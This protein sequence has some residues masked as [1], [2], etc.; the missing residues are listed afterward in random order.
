M[1]ERATRELELRF[2]PRDTNLSLADFCNLRSQ[3]PTGDLRAVLTVNGRPFSESECHVDARPG[4]SRTHHG[5]DPASNRAGWA[6][7]DV[8]PG[9]ESVIRVR[10]EGDGGAVVLG[11]GVY[12][13]SGARI[14]LGGVTIRRR[15]QAG[16]HEYSLIGYE[17]AKITA[18]RRELELPIARERPGWLISGTTG[19]GADDDQEAV[20]R[21][22]LDGAELSVD[23]AGGLAGTQ[24]DT[25][26]RKI[27]LQ[28]PP[29]VTGTMLL[30]Y[31]ERL[32][33][34]R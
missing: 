25:T 28:V 17:A 8:R 14:E 12:E 22:L 3:P 26:P 11:V 18:A 4:E 6:A 32:A 34:G 33:L 2:T 9:E 24:V 29:G 31:Y 23:A 21:V 16:D 5:D 15:L 27:R 20:V 1:S 30:A 7:L 13:L 10:V 19:G